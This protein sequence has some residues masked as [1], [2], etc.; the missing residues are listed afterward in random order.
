M[1]SYTMI[2]NQ[3]LEQIKQGVLKEGDAIPKEIDL[4]VQFGVSRPTVRQAL[5][6]LVNDGYLKRVRGKG[7]YVTRPKVLQQYT[8]F[9]ESYNYEMEK[10]GLI[11]ATKV[12]EISL[13]YPSHPVQKQLAISPED[14]IVK[15]QRLR[16]VSEN[17]NL[18]PI[19][20]TT[21]YFP[22]QL[23]PDAFQFDFEKRSFY[24]VLGEHGIQVKRGTRLLE[25]KPLYGEKAALFDLPDGSP[26]HYISSV[27][28]DETGRPIEYS[29]NYY[30][31]DRNKFIIEIVK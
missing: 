22:F 3:L 24:D 4:S 30:P 23:L 2:Y 31:A 27:G 5:N 18:K 12:L 28:Y 11:P 9:I 29:E 8:Q 21:V 13:T 10:K 19:I 20:L 26:C 14:K 1:H 17:G 15:L 25:I 6:M 7:S 16:S